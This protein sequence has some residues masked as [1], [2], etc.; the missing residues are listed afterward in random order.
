MMFH[1]A[2]I[3][4][5]DSRPTALFA[6]MASAAAAN[7]WTSINGWAAPL[8]YRSAH[9]EYERLRTGAGLVDLGPL[10]RYTVRG[11]A[12]AA[13][14]GRL[15]TAPVAALAPAESARG[16]ILDDEGFVVDKIEVARLSDE[17]Y[18]FCASEPHARRLQ[19]ARRCLSASVENITGA[20]AALGILGPQA[21]EV[22]AAAGIEIHSDVLAAQI[23]VRGVETSARP[24]HFGPLP[25]VEII[26]P[27][28][29]ALT[30]WERLRRAAAPPP[31]GLEAL[32]IHRIEGGAPCPGV[33]FA[34]ADRTQN[35]RARRRPRE[36]GLDHLA[37]VGRAWF[38]G[39]RA[40]QNPPPAER[41]LVVLSADAEHVAP[42]AAVFSRKTAVG[43]I[44]SSA[45][46]P[47]LRRAIAFA[48]LAAGASEKPLEIA[49]S[50][51]GADRSVA[52]ILETPEYRLAQSWRAA[53]GAATE[54]RS[55]P[56]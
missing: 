17:L 11:D 7:A 37:P 33:D 55:R 38:N 48:D 53:E 52:T 5:G 46:S 19:L 35:A 22:A 34:N 20:V 56:V 32:E 6:A 49:R 8:Y 45:Y 50:G 2:D 14:L 13:M 26:Y 16:L 29:E 24:V 42:G 40:L 4:P 36:L 28:E 39:R 31:V 1:A 41:E 27:A 47:R 51:D 3:L 10:T 43:R 54:S 25:G 21:N 30:L 18:L 23:R 12:A 15:T 44:T 9:E